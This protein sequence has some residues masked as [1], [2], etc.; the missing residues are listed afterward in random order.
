MAQGLSAHKGD[1]LVMVGTRK[2]S[3]IISS[4]PTRK[5]WQVSGPHNPGC[6]VFHLAYDHR[7][8]GAIFSA[9]NHMIWGPQLEYSQDLGKTW[10]SAKEQPRFSGHNDLTV[11]RLWH[12]EPGRDS[13]PGVL[14]AGV[15][16]AALFKSE[17]SGMTWHE[18]PGLS[19][20][21][22]REQWQPGNGG[23]CLH[24]IVVDPSRSDRMWV[25]MSA[26]GVFGTADAG[27]S[28][29][30][31][32]KGVRADFMPDRYPEWGQCVHKVLLHKSRP[33][34]LYQQNHCGVYRS[35]SGGKDW[36]DISEGLSSRF[37][38]VLGVHSQDPDT[39]YVLPEDEA[40]GQDTGGMLRYVT[41]AK[42]RVFR[43][44]NRGQN[45][46][47]L[48]KGLPQKNAYLHAMREGMATDSFDPCGVYVETTNGQIFYS[49]NG[50]DDW[51][52]LVDYL[53]PI[54]SVD[55]GVVV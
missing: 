3:F 39:I 46:E 44:R 43:S 17:D 12:V 10:H 38:F 7:N 15:E 29:H 16:P 9:A 34:V 5:H 37:G 33:E 1:V 25:G 54:N 42:F 28:W 27:E 20:H 36:Q 23:L 32:N 55:C 53:P 4:D 18:V 6:D 50:G 49:R 19:H 24:S 47:P 40:L 35:D 48:T 8:G 51:E 21:P 41:H 31:L 52:L 30:P 14:Y 13:E 45:W 26:V 11:K 22:T 2:G